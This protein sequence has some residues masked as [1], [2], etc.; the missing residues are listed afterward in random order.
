MTGSSTKNAEKWKDLRKEA[1][2]H[3]RKDVS[4]QIYSGW[5]SALRS[6]NSK[7]LWNKISRK[8]T[9][10]SSEASIKRS[11]EIYPC[12]S[13]TKDRLKVNLPTYLIPERL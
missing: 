8:G 1:V 7:S 3:L 13:L 5:A 11:L 10:D 2:S 12:T 6:N 9:S 4:H